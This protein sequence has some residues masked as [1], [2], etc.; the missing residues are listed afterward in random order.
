[1]YSIPKYNAKD[2]SINT[3]AEAVSARLSMQNTRCESTRSK[4]KNQRPK[5]T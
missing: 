3:K 2:V 1:M 5:S 4:Q